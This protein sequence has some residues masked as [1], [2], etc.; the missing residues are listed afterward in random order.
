[1]LTDRYMQHLDPRGNYTVV[2]Q[3]SVALTCLQLQQGKEI[4]ELNQAIK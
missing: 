3:E 4:Y 1:M 2:A